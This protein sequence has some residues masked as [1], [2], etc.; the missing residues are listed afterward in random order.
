MKKNLKGGKMNDKVE[1]RELE[2]Q[3]IASIKKK[4]KAWQIPKVFPKLMMKLFSFLEEKRIQP[5]GAP[6]A[7]YYGF[8]K[9]KGEIEV[10]MPISESI[11]PEG[12]IE[13]SNL[14]G[15]KTAYYIYTGK[16]RKISKI[17]DIMK[18]WIQKEGYKYTNIWWEVYLTDPHKEPD[19]NKWQTEINL[20]LE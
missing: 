11:T 20:L 12:E 16:L 8:E 2:S 14:P 15:G 5:I 6:L 18:E 4:I 19:Q 17:Y 7:I 10:G 1:L 13:S 3:P 9:G